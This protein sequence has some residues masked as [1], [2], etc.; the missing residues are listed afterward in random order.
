MIIVYP[1]TCARKDAISR[2]PGR[3]LRSSNSRPMMQLRPWIAVSDGHDD[4]EEISAKQFEPIATLPVYF[5]S[6]CRDDDEF[7][8]KSSN[9]IRQLI[10][11][12]MVSRGHGCCFRLKPSRNLSNQL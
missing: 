8:V 11:N 2:A 5:V 1:I 3:L 10:L 12:L 6:E 7:T 9:L 4:D